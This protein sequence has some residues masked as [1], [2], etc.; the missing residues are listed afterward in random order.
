MLLGTLVVVVPSSPP[1]EARTMQLGAAQLQ[2][3]DAHLWPGFEGYCYTQKLWVGLL[4]LVQSLDLLVSIAMSPTDVGACLELSLAMRTGIPSSVKWIRS[5]K[6]V[7]QHLEPALRVQVAADDMDAFSTAAASECRVVG[8]LLHAPTM[9]A[10][11]SNFNLPSLFKSLESPIQ[12]DRILIRDDTDYAA[13]MAAGAPLVLT[14][15]PMNVMWEMLKCLNAVELATVAMVCTTL[16]HLTYDTAPGLKLELFPHQKKA[17]KW[18]L[19]RERPPRRLIHPYILAGRIDTVTNKIHALPVPAMDIR[20]GFLCDE[21]GLGKT[22]TMI[23]LLLRTQGAVSQVPTDSG[24]VGG[25][26][27]LRSAEPRPRSL[28]PS[29]ASLIIVPDTLVAHWAFQIDTHTSNLD[30]YLDIKNEAPAA[31]VLMNFD[32]VITTFARLTSH[33]QNMRPLT[34]LETRAPSR[35][36]REGQCMYVDGTACKGLSPFLQVHWV[37]IIVDEG[38]KLSSTTI[39]NAIQM[40]CALSADKRWIM[41]GTPTRNVAAS[42]GLRH[43][44]GLL[45]FFRDRPYGTNDDKPWMLAITKPFEAR[46]AV[47]YVRLRQLLNRIMLRHVKSE[48]KSIPVPIR[49]TVVVEPSP[50]EFRIYNGVVGVVRGNLVVTKWDPITPGSLH[51]DSLLNPDNRKDALTALSNLRLASCG[52]GQMEVLLS[53]A[54]YKETIEYMDKYEIPPGLQEAVKLY[55][56]DAPNGLCTPCLL[57]KRAQQFLMVVP[58]GHMLCADCIDEHVSVEGCYRHGEIAYATTCPW[59]FKHFDWEQFQKLQPGFDYKWNA[60]ETTPATAAGIEAPLWSSSKGHHVLARIQNLLHEAASADP[61]ATS[62]F[63]PRPIKCIIFSDFREQIFRIRHEF[64]RLR[65]RCAS[66]VQGDSMKTRLDELRKFQRDPNLHVLFM[67]EIG[68]IGL[69]LSFVTHIFL[70]DEIWDKS[71]EDQVIARAHRMGATGPVVVEQLQM[72]GSMEALVRYRDAHR[73]DACVRGS[74]VLHSKE[75]RRKKTSKAIKKQ[76]DKD[77]SASLPRVYHVL[78]HVRLIDEQ[79][80]GAAVV[81]PLPTPY[82]PQAPVSIRRPADDTRPAKRTKSVRFVVD[83]PITAS[84]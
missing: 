36:G 84:S 34:A 81:P 5:A 83:A 49:T 27:G 6:Y 60:D 14:D 24:D 31:D 52:G 61:S 26:Y 17:L 29:V 10:L 47:G 69:D 76:A 43:L 65:L 57:C 56:R 9:L 18:M 1:V 23:A 2:D 44:H 59:C 78:N 45:R 20:G 39:T 70:M 51:K 68:A 82:I 37:R 74:H 50:L 28:L 15:L 71:V 64:Q 48:V 8:C 22:I 53:A 58:C 62:L 73:T 11:E 3:P 19:H 16:Q 54:H 79:G 13:R 55:M 25:S 12:A 30:V 38:H 46:L 21:P 77:D 75:R 63:P 35:L 67:T 42:D 80:D 41:T 40:L 72:R 33:W 66:F 32:V 7:L 4:G